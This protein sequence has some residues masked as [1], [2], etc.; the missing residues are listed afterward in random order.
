[1]KLPLFVLPLAASVLVLACGSPATSPGGAAAEDPAIVEQPPPPAVTAPAPTTPAPPAV[2]PACSPL[3]PRDTPLEV[4]VLPDAGPTPF[5]SVLSRA[6][7]SI[8]VMVYQMGPGPILDTLEAKARAGVKVQIILDVFQKD[9]NEKYMIRLKAAGAD[10]IWSDP[11]F[12][13][14]HAK[15]IVVDGAEAVISTGNYADFRMKME[16]NYA[17]RDAD[18]ADVDAL[19]K[20]FD[21]DFSRKVPDLTCT[22]L[23]V[24]PVNSKQRLLDFIATARKEIVVESMQLADTDVRDALA[25]RKTA[26]VEVRVLLADPAW[27]SANSDAATFLAANAIEARQ[28]KVLAVHVKSVL[29]DGKTAYAG[30]E[31]LSWTSLTKNREVGVLITEPANVATMQATFEKDWATATPF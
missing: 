15:V 19:V 10:V 3:V 21:A 30:S 25:A 13:Y 28:M 7:K 1:M 2:K 22:R 20:L 11:Q 17:V 9:V 12:Q 6:T 5:V 18:A 26:G 14:M 23:L 29:V 4:A 31:N 8:R 16:R 27:I 24:S